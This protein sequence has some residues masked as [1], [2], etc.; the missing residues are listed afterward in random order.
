MILGLAAWAFWLRGDAAAAQGEA[1]CIISLYVIHGVFHFAGSPLFFTLKRPDWAL[2]EVPYL[3]GSVPALAI[4]LRDWSV[5]RLLD[6][7]AIPCVGT[8]RGVPELQDNAAQQ[9]V[10]C[11]NRLKQMLR[12]SEC[13]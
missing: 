2:I 4:F 5:T 1:T 9:T 6:D 11:A 10:R 12:C 7:F 8:F 13:L 3:R